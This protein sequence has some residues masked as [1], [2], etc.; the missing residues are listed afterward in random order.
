MLTTAATVVPNSVANPKIQSCHANVLC[1][2]TAKTISE[3]MMI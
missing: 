3:E 1:S 2:L